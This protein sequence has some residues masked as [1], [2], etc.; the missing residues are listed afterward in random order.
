[1]GRRIVEQDDGV[2]VAVY[3]LPSETHIAFIIR[4]NVSQALASQIFNSAEEILGDMHI[5]DEQRLQCRQVCLKYAPYTSASN[6]LGYHIP[7]LAPE[8]TV[9]SVIVNY[10]YSDCNL[11]QIILNEL[12]SVLHHCSTAKVFDKLAG[13]LAYLVLTDK[14]VLEHR[15]VALEKQRCHFVKTLRCGEVLPEF[16]SR[17]GIDQTEGLPLFIATSQFKQY[18]LLQQAYEHGGSSTSIALITE[19]EGRSAVG[20][21]LQPFRKLLPAFVQKHRAV[22]FATGNASRSTDY[23]GRLLQKALHYKG[24]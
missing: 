16:W 22:T 9:Q 11:H 23:S 7:S 15:L 12:V 24:R 5:T 8:V 3:E 10:S 21:A 13:Y 1:V 6:A 20:K 14:G 18:A 2:I 19:R 4:S 17:A